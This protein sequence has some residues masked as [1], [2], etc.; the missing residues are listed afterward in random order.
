[1]EIDCIIIDTE[2]FI[3]SGVQ[4]GGDHRL[5]STI[6]IY[7]EVALVHVR[8]KRVDLVYH[9][10]LAYNVF[11]AI[12]QFSAADREKNIL[13]YVI[14]SRHCNGCPSSTTR[15]KNIIVARE[16]IGRIIASL[17]PVNGLWAK[18]PSFERRFLSGVDNGRPLSKGEV[19]AAASA[20]LPRIADLASIRC[21]KYEAL[22]RF[23]PLPSQ[24][25]HVARF[26]SAASKKAIVHCCAEECLA[27]A[28]WLVTSKAPPPTAPSLDEGAVSSRPSLDD[29]DRKRFLRQRRREEEGGGGGGDGGDGIVVGSLPSLHS[30]S[31]SSPPSSVYVPVTSVEPR[32]E[33][34]PV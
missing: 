11:S 12:D 1:M 31:S 30:S 6:A 24:I 10:V 13:S 15:G 27:F 32:A 21:P 34:R 20:S 16:E 18:G 22:P 26:H 28:L 29:V 5:P 33:R 25:E 23:T 17:A 14:P 9:E 2:G 3:F 19:K 7:T 8:G 4:E